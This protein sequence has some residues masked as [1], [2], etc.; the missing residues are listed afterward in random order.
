MKAVTCAV[1]VCYKDND[2]TRYLVVHPTGGN[3]WSLPKGIRDEGESLEEAAVRELREETGLKITISDLD[4]QGVYKYNRKKNY[5][6]FIY[7]SPIVFNPYDFGCD[8]FYSLEDNLIPEIDAYGYVDAKGLLEA[9]NPSQSKIL[10][11]YFSSI[12]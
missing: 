1:L 5:A 10:A 8:S 12:E 7:H 2:E 6:L 11:D 4:F 9:L 3:H